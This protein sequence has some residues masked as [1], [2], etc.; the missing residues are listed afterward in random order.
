[1]FIIIMGNGIIIVDPD[2]LGVEYFVQPHTWDIR[3]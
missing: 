1:M 3:K 2:N